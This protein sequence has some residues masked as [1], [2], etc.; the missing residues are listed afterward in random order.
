MGYVISPLIFH[1]GNGNVTT[2]S[3]KN[4]YEGFY[5][6][7]DGDFR[8]DI[9]IEKLLKC[10][11]E[12]FKRAVMKV[13]SSKS[14]SLSIIKGKCQEIKFAI[15]NNVIPT[16]CEKSVKSLGRCY[17]LPLTDRHRWQ[18]LLKQLKDGL[19]STDKCDLIAKGKLWCVYF[20]LIPRLAWPMQIYEVSLSRIEKME[21]LISKFSK[22]MVRSS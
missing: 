22:E 16:I 9:T 6:W 20:G 19:L 17:S 10:L 18:D 14:R 12:V 3:K 7:C 11:Q 2:T 5:G 4:I 13:K 8:V 21:S 15:N 1:F